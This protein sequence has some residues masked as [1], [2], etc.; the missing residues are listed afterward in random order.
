MLFDWKWKK[1]ENRPLVLRCFRLFL[2]LEIKPN[3]VKNL[4]IFFSQ[5]Q[6]IVFNWIHEIITETLFHLKNPNFSKFEKPQ[7]I[8]F[9]SGYRHFNLYFFVNA[10]SIGFQLDGKKIFS[11]NGSS[12]FIF[13]RFSFIPVIVISICMSLGTQ[14]QSDFIWMERKY[15]VPMGHLNSLFA[16]FFHNE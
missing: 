6:L 8:F 15:F 7:N 12:Q 13:R 11:S 2:T 4:H 14:C 16:S 5:L 10:M 9:N 3:D 1:P